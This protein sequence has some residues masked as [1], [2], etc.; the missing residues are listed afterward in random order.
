MAVYNLW[1]FSN[2]EKFNFLSFFQEFWEKVVKNDEIWKFETIRSVRVKVALSSTRC[3]LTKRER[4]RVESLPLRKARNLA[5]NHYWPKTFNTPHSA[6]YMYTYD[7]DKE[8]SVNA[9]NIGGRMC[10]TTSP[11]VNWG[12]LLFEGYS[13]RVWFSLKRLDRTFAL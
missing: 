12:S 4:E 1:R 7:D 11:W 2:V 9:R 13:L 6:E 8:E 10:R 3:A 5:A